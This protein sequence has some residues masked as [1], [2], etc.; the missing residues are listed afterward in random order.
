MAIVAGTSD[1]DSYGAQNPE[2]ERKAKNTMT[3]PNPLSMFTPDT[4]GLEPELANEVIRLAADEQ[5]TLAA[6]NHRLDMLAT[7]VHGV[8]KGDFC[9]FVVQGEK[10]LGKSHTVHQVL[11]MYD[12]TVP[13]NEEMP[14]EQR[15]SIRRFTGKITPLQLFLAM[16]EWNTPKCILLF[17]DCDSA[18]NEIDALNVLKAAMDTKARRIVTW[19]TTSRLVREQ[20]FEFKGQVIVIT[21][22]HMTSSHYKAFLD[23]V[24]KFPLKMSQREKLVKIKEIAMVSDSFD[25]D[26]AVQVMRHIENNL[27]MIGPR[28][29]MRTF[30]KTYE[31]V[32]I[33][34]WKELAIETVFAEEQ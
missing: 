34:I 24:H 14:E 30:V 33:P 21:N 23:R 25:R 11:D 28:L 12:P 8:C 10:G 6:V 18:W 29:S 1:N 4:D 13:G 31:L 9:G 17:D 15:R 32:K 20:S 19:A 3:T 16:Q 26:M 7:M 5:Q 22:A 2:N 27:E